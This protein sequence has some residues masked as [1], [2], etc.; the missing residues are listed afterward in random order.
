MTVHQA[1][2]VLGED[3]RKRLAKGSQAFEILADRDVFLGGDL[4]RICVRDASLPSGKAIVT[5]TLQS[6]RAKQLQIN[7]RRSVRHEQRSRL[8]R[9][10]DGHCRPEEA[11]RKNTH[12]CPL[13]WIKAI[14]G[15]WK[16]KRALFTRV[17]KGLQQLRD[18]WWEPLSR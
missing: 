3:G 15:L 16:P 13:Y 9:D 7:C 6:N 2:K 11:A 8:G 4:L 10:A 5:F 12:P 14:N 18:S 1:R 17:V